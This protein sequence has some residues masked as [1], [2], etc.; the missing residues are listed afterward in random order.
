MVVSWCIAGINIVLLYQSAVS[1]DHLSIFAFV[2]LSLWDV[3]LCYREKKRHAELENEM[4]DRNAELSELRRHS[5]ELKK[6]VSKLQRGKAA[7]EVYMK[8][9][10]RKF[11]AALLDCSMRMIKLQLKLKEKDDEIDKLSKLLKDKEKTEA[12]MNKA[13]QHIL[14][15]L[16]AVYK[17]DAFAEEKLGERD[18]CEA[19]VQL[20]A[21]M[22]ANQ[23]DPA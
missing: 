19:L 8:K 5:G 4:T 22:E 15:E 21:H 14:A 18:N 12:N 11:C 7:L 3:S 13:L 2:V 16:H 1:K 9:T 10:L 23:F 17:I 20:D 6:E